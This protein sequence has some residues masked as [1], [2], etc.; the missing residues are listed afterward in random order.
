MEMCHLINL[1]CFEISS[2]DNELPEK[3]YKN[4]VTKIKEFIML[5]KDLLFKMYLST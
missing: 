3:L 4:N 1:A 5:S 2:I